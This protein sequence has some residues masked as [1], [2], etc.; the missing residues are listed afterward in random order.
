MLVRG[1]RDSA[2]SGLWFLESIDRVN[3]A[4]QGT[5][6]LEQMMRDVLDVVLDVFQCDRALLITTHTDK[7][8]LFLPTIERAVSAYPGLG[9]NRQMP[10]SPALIEAHERLMAARQPLAL[11]EDE[12]AGTGLTERLGVRALLVTA[13]H[14]KQ[15]PPYL[16]ALHQCSRPRVWTSDERELVTEIGERIAVAINALL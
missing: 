2:R 11:G 4:I 6:E 12:L 7:P 16:F 1:V 3:R 14:P 5:Q 15:M 13:I 9:E 8:G 10:R